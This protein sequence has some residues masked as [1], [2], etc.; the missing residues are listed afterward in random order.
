MPSSSKLSFNKCQEYVASG[1]VAYCPTFT[2]WSAS[3]FKNKEGEYIY[4][5]TQEELRAWFKGND[6]EA[7]L[8]QMNHKA[9]EVK[10]LVT[11]LLTKESLNLQMDKLTLVSHSYGG[12]SNIIACNLIPEIKYSINEDPS[13]AWAGDYFKDIVD[14]KIGVVQPLLLSYTEQYWNFVEKHELHYDL[15]FEKLIE[16]SVEK[17]KSMNWK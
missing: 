10:D 11:Y 6:K 4:P 14:G 9:E 3:S 2:D 17:A 13:F 8:S 5:E 7:V 15:V 16:T 1:C 12:M